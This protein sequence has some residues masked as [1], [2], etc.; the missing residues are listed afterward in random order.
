MRAAAE[1]G[2]SLAA[3]VVAAIAA[4]GRHRVAG[5]WWRHCVQLPFKWAVVELPNMVSGNSGR[6]FRFAPRIAMYFCHE[7]A[8]KE[9]K[10][11]R[12]ATVLSRASLGHAA[13]A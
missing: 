5:E 4:A 9:P 10:G 8:S 3:A 6:H 7:Q 1:A 2:S 13:T 11:Q 12:G